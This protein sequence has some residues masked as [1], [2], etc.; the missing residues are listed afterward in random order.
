MVVMLKYKV[1]LLVVKLLRGAHPGSCS[2]PWSDTC[3]AGVVR[4]ALGLFIAGVVR[5]ALFI[6]GVVRIALFI[7]GI[8]TIAI[9]IPTSGTGFYSIFWQGDQTRFTCQSCLVGLISTKIGLF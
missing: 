2:I 1:Y 9:L 5:I 3:I 7:A 4:I 6:A 8:V